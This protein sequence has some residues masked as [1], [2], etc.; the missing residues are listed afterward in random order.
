MNKFLISLSIISAITNQPVYSA[1]NN[2]DFDNYCNQICRDNPYS[3]I[4][5]NCSGWALNHFENQPS[6]NGVDKLLDDAKVWHNK[7]FNH[8]KKWLNEKNTNGG[9]K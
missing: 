5:N 4:A 7:Y 9:E 8:Y 2:F 3:C 6:F 1:C